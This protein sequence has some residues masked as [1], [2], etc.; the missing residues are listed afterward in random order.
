MSNLSCQAR[1]VIADD[2]PIVQRAV[3]DCLNALPGFRVV[4]TVASGDELLSVLATH[5]V[6][7]IVTDF[8]MQQADEDKDGLRL[9][10]HLL[11]VHEHTPIVVFT[12]LTN[13]GVLSQLCRMGV[14]GLVGKGEEICELGLVCSRVARGKGQFL[15]PGIAH[16][17]AAA[18][19]LK[20]GQADFQ[21]LTQKELEVVRLFSHGT[22]LTDIA[23][24][25][26]RS[27]GTVATQKRS[28]MRK[29]HV[30]TNVDLVTCA[31]EQGLV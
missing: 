30:D 20:P 29:L 27:L 8:S 14:A 5:E 25:L 17:L 16:K 18:G 6:D 15:S 9:I 12:M 31:R 28:A 10:A 2:H 7:L 26:S 1:V 22:S 21:L 11:R 3:S 19:S 4:L 24:M 23:R 13:S